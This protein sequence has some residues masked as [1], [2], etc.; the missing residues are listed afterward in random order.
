MTPQMPAYRLLDWEHPP[1]MATVDVPRPGPG[2]VLVRV[3]GNGLCHSD[4]GMAQMP[5]SVGELVGW[6]MPFTH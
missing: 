6:A 4:I 3:A 2:Q 5:A 1:Q